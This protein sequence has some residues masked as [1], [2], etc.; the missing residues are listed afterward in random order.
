MQ[1]DQ[2]LHTFWFLERFSFKEKQDRLIEHFRKLDQCLKINIIY[3]H[4]TNLEKI[5]T[6]QRLLSVTNI[7]VYTIQLHPRYSGKRHSKIQID[8]K[9][10][11]FQ[12]IK[13]L[14]E[15]SQ[16]P[17]MDY[18]FAFQDLHEN[19]LDRILLIKEN[20]STT[21]YWGSV[22]QDAEKIIDFEKVKVN[23]KNGVIF[24]I[25][26]NNL[27]REQELRY[28]LISPDFPKEQ[29]DILIKQKLILQLKEDLF[30]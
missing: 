21:L 26:K 25:P 20:Q 27:C 4:Y 1:L 17:L 8:T 12:E 23:E 19:C 18:F 29:L 10:K 6:H 13:S 11:Y 5:I 2:P 16:G 30:L 7:P 22:Y 15:W 24:T 14:I 28:S 9:S 3:P